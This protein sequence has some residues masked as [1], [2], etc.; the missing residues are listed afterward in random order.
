MPSLLDDLRAAVWTVCVSDLDQSTR[1]YCEGLGFTEGQSNETTIEPGSELAAAFDIERGKTRGRF[2]S[3]P[4]VNLY[5]LTF[6]EPKPIGGRGR[7]P[8]NQIGPRSLIF[9]CSNP[10]AVAARL[11]ELGGK[12]VHEDKRGQFAAVLVTDPDGFSLQLEDL[13]FAAFEAAF[14]K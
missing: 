11:E 6:D 2:L 14:K 13:P 3:R 9:T 1:F 8:T 12:I 7:K 10:M 4:D 5:L